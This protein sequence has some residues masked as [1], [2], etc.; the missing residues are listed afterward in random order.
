V[1]APH[2]IKEGG[3]RWPDAEDEYQ[4]YQALLAI[5][6]PEEDGAAVPAVLPEEL[7]ERLGAYLVKAVREAK[8]RSSWLRPDHDYERAVVNFVQAIT[9]GAGARRFLPRFASFA[10][11]VARHGAVNSLAQVVLWLAS[12]GVPDVYQGSEAWHLCLVDPDNRHPVDFA[13]LAARLT[14]L[15]PWLTRAASPVGHDEVAHLVAGLLARWS[16]GRIKTWCLA[17]GLRHRQRDPA[18]FLEGAYVPLVPTPADAPVVAFARTRASRAVLVVVPR[19]A[20]RLMRDGAWPI[21]DVWGSA[22][23]E[24]PSSVGGATLCDRLTGRHVAVSPQRSVSLASLFA[25]MPCAWLE[26]CASPQSA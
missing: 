24:V 13:A 25:V 22:T 18:L 20:G 5:W 3:T 1:N 14:D 21:G 12:P 17:T 7:V 6:P 9:R 10:R 8:R 2:R 15:D 16:D 19:L 4:L 11:V 23:L 26:P